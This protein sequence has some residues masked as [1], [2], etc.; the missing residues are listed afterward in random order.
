LTGGLP[1]YVR[2]AAQLSETQY[3]GNVAAMCDAVEAHSHLVE[4]PQELILSRS[5][6]ALS[7]PVRHCVAVLS[8]SDVPLRQAEAARLVKAALDLDAPALA[9]AVRQ[10]RPLGVVRTYGAQQIQIHDAFRV[11]GLRLFSGFPPPQVTRGR[12]ALKE[13]ILESFEKSQD[14]SRFPLLIRTM[15]ELGELKPLVEVATEEWF[16]ELGVDSGIWN[17]LES[18]AVNEA[19][20]PEQRFYVLDGL[21]FARM[22]AGGPEKAGPLLEAMEALVTDHGLGHRE[23]LV[24]LLKRM[25]FEAAQG[26][27]AAFRQAMARATVLAPSQ[28]D[29]Q[30]ILQYNIAH[31]LF[32][33]S[34]CAEAEAIAR[35]L[36]EAYYDVLGLTPESV[37][38]LSNAKI[39]EKLKP[40]PTLQD[41][42]KHLADSLDLVA[43]A[44]NAQNRDAMFARVHA[45]KFYG[46]ANAVDSL[47]RVTQDLVD[48]F[49]VRG[50]YVGARQVI[51]NQLLPA[52]I[53][54]K[55]LDRIV[56]VRSQ[57]AVVLGYCGDFDSANAEFARLGAY[58]SGLTA[59]QRREVENQRGLVAQLRRVGVQPD[60]LIDGQAHISV[61]P[62]VRRN[63]ACPCGSGMKHKK[64]HGRR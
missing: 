44:T 38:G 40:T 1:L 42:L 14:A 2:T 50:D 16:H 3:G 49:V 52:V 58:G 22:K 20:A 54:H 41:D 23:E 63:D 39:A 45:A 21:V 5:F 60:K 32:R 31:A 30:R 26:N 47:I 4:T 48:E 61:R 8:L 17:A 33:L 18:A 64:C 59:H 6:D 62:K 51:E 7:E 28:P 57:Y 19:I 15:V 56:S 37:L 11:L 36:V 9:A 12:E 29:H 34:H 25:A 46:L 24:V 10:L 55:M 43:R 13:V 35:E 53:G 27:E